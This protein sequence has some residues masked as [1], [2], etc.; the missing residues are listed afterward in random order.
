M[1]V[2]ASYGREMTDPVF[3]ALWQEPTN[4]YTLDVNASI[5]IWDWGE[6]DARIE[7]TEIGLRQTE[8]R[9][10]EAEAQIRA[11]VQNEVRN[12]G[13][14]QSRTQAMQTNLEL[15]SDIS[16]ETLARYT[17]GE[18]TVFELLQSFQRETDTAR[19]FLDAFIGLRRA[20][21]R[22]QEMTF[23]DFERNEPVLDRFGVSLPGLP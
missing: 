23:Y 8:L 15:A 7:A 21:A 2:S 5:P 14:Y 13:E 10:E 20:M 17:R 9:M 16:T 22:L 1:D 4:T 6:R 18:A 3:D 12:V 11:N 19:N